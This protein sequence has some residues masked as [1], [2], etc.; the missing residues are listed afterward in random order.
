MIVLP[1]ASFIRFT[2]F[3]RLLVFAGSPSFK[4]VYHIV[5]AVYHLLRLVCWRLE[6]AVQQSRRPDAIEAGES[7]TDLPF[8]ES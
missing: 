4:K 3:L 5:G 6:G 2:R 8:S 7:K 1:V